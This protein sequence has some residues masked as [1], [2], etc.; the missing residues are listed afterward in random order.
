[1]R[2]V[3]TRTVR[4]TVVV[5]VTASAPSSRVSTSVAGASV[6]S[7]GRPSRP[8]MT[9]VTGGSV[10]TVVLV[11][12]T[13][14]SAS[15][16]ASRWIAANMALGQDEKGKRLTNVG[17]GDGGG[18]WCGDGRGEEMGRVGQR[19]G[20]AEWVRRARLDGGAARESSLALTDALLGVEGNGARIHEG[21]GARAPGGGGELDDEGEDRVGRDDVWS[22]VDGGGSGGKGAAGGGG[23]ERR[24]GGDAS[25]DDGLGDE[26]A[27]GDAEDWGKDDGEGGASEE[28]E[29]VGGVGRRGGAGGY[30]ECCG[31]DV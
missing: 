15:A 24:D 11:L 5:A 28:I 8:P 9:L 31:G 4:S 18:W 27:I 1:M 21:R 29:G 30:D 6:V 10:Y 23:D 2:V 16:A 26:V 13:A 20:G 19:R 12:L 14:L 3:T 25:G 7:T 22:G 17:H